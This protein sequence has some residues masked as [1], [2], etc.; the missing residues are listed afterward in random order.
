MSIFL[1][2]FTEKFLFWQTVS[3]L[4]SVLGDIGNLHPGTSPP[5]YLIVVTNS[6]QTGPRAVD[7]TDIDT[8][9]FLNL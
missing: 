3:E 2:S 1:F 6:S 7:H 8:K 4:S 5:L 9:P